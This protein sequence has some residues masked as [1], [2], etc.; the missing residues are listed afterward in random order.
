MGREMNVYRNTGLL[1]YPVT[2]TE[3][4]GGLKQVQLFGKGV[5]FTNMDEGCKFQEEMNRSNKEYAFWTNSIIP[6][7]CSN[8]TEESR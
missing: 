1:V 6:Y 4:P 5:F 3:I 2:Y 8:N 7:I